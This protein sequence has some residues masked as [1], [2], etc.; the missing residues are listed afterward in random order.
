MR[1]IFQDN[2]LQKSFLKKG[3]V[4][5]PML[6]STQVMYLLE[7]IAKLRPYDNFAPK[8]S[9]HCS[10]LDPNLE[11]KRQTYNL[12]RGIFTPFVNEYLVGYEILNCNF[13]VK[14]PHTGEFQ[15]HQNW[16]AI[17]DINDTTVTIWCPLVD[18]IES[19]GAI[20]VVAGSH[21]ILPHIEAPNSPPYFVNFQEALIEKYL[22]PFPM[23]AGEA[24]IFD[25]GL[26][27]WSRKNDSDQSRIAIQILCI[28]S[29]A[30]PTF[31]FKECEERFELIHADS[32]FFLTSHV[33]DLYGD[34]K[35]DWKSVG[36][37]KNQ[38]R[39]ITEEEFAKLLKNGEEIRSQIYS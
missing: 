22:K 39:L 25:D 3:Y 1:Q 27:H 38:N 9:Y 33:S 30:T 26:I 10:F 36:F 17:A 21:K 7:E 12:I 13:Y 18:V 24:I 23:K 14:P 19:N 29:D 28:P 11:Y 8:N 31:F 16:P 32:E 37:V 15:I 34:R 5:V 4:Q 2:D 35:P 6:S 20:Q